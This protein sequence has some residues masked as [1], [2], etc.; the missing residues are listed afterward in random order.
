[1]IPSS[2]KLE[3]LQSMHDDPLSGHLGFAKT[4]NKIRNRFYWTGLQKDVL[5]YV[6]GCESC[7]SRKGPTNQKPAGLLQPI[8][9]GPPFHRV[10]LDLLGPF[11][12]S[13]RGNKMIICATEYCTRWVETRAILDGVARNVAKFMLEQIICRHGAP[14][15][16]LTDQGKVFQSQLVTELLHQMGSN[17]QLTTA[18]H[19]Q[20][21]GLTECFN[22][23]LA[24][25][26]FMYT[27][28]AQTDWD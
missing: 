26:L 24:D 1:M 25:L 13:R 3:I 21:N 9:V 10:G 20:C 4:F 16:I 17:S 6:K 15:N 12:R 7:Q 11:R 18:Y 2:L 28:T 8:P 14:S 27:N 23:T 5:R 19:P 22:K